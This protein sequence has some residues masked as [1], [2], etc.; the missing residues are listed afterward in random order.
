MIRQALVGGHHPEGAHDLVAAADTPPMVT[1]D[2]GQREQLVGDEVVT[3]Q[4]DHVTEAD[5][6]PPAREVATD[7]DLGRAGGCVAEGAVLLGP[8]CF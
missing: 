8:H 7:V 1:R 5:E 4:G 6:Q 3:T 2:Q